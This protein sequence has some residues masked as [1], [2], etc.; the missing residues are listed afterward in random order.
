MNFSV[1]LTYI[2]P[3]RR[4]LMMVLSLLL[5]AYLLAMKIMGRQLRPHS[6]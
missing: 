2:T 1:L 3:R 6:G 5:P 4:V